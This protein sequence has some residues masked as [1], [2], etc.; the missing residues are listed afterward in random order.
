MKQRHVLFSCG[1]LADND[2]IGFG[3]NFKG[4]QH[5]PQLNQCTKPKLIITGSEDDII[6]AETVKRLFTE[7]ADPKEFHLIDGADHF[8]WGRQRIAMFEKTV[9]F[10]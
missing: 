4:E 2:I 7:I 10:F 8:W 5:I 1:K 9:S 3:F 6:P